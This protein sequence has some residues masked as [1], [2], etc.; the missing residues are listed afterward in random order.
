M[1]VYRAADLVQ[2]ILQLRRLRERPLLRV[3]SRGLPRHVVGSHATY[4]RIAV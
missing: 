1:F 3:M 2:D 4:D